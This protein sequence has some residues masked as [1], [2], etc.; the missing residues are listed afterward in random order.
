[1]PREMSVV[2]PA[3][4]CAACGKPIRAYDNIPVLSWLFLRGRARRPRA[5]PATG[6]R[7]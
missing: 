5:P 7:R 2:R 4:S 6:H 1:V 3:S